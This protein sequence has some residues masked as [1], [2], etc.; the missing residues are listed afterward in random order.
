MQAALNS[1]WPADDDGFL[2]SHHLAQQWLQLYRHDIQSQSSSSSSSVGFDTLLV[3]VFDIYIFSILADPLTQT[4]SEKVQV[5]H[6]KH[7]KIIGH[8]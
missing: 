3:S 5:L 2:L 6:F 1:C 7:G 4:D 8:F